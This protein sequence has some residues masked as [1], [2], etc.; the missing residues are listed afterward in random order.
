MR[1]AI[2][3]TEPA[4]LPAGDRSAD[5]AGTVARM[6]MVELLDRVAEDWLG[7][8]VPPVRYVVG[9]WTPEPASAACPSCGASVGRA[10]VDEHGCASCRTQRLPYDRFVRL[11]A[12]VDP[13]R[14]WVRAVKYEPRWLEMGEFLGR[15]MAQTLSTRTVFDPRRTLVLPMP[16]PPLRRWH[17]GIDHARVLASAAARQ[18]RARHVTWLLR[19]ADGR[20]QA[21]LSAAARRRLG[22]RGVR[23]ARRPPSLAG[24]DVVLVDDVRTTGSTLASAARRLRRLRPQRITALV[25]AVADEGARLPNTPL[26]G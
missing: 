2:V 3:P 24:L 23:L 22:G 12:Y 18:L 19:R 9:E 4:I 20:P 11:G 7:H 25:V 17:R 15:A 6:S 13:L 1:V 26:G 21:T 8:V 16:M 14:T 5:A 10:E